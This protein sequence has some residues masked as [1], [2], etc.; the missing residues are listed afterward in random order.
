MVVKFIEFDVSSLRFEQVNVS[1]KDSI[2]LPRVGSGECPYFQLPWL[3][4]FGVPKQSK[5]FPTDKDRLFVQ[6][7]LE[8]KLLDQFKALDKIMS[9]EVMKMKMFGFNT[10]D[11]HQYQPLVKES[12]RGEFMKVKL[13]TNYET[14]NIETGVIVND[15]DVGDIG[16][17][18]EF[19]KHVHYN[20]KVRMIVKFVKVWVVNKKFGI[21][22]KAVRIGVEETSEPRTNN[23]IDFID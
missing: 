10:G 5:Y 20:S 8:G 19:E 16:S 7:P 18:L 15:A 11:N 13:L 3:S 14:G 4:C 22:V 12:A 6:I 17:L 23:Q 1:P 9:S 2:L 21:T